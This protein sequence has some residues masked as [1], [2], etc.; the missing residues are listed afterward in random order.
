MSPLG[1]LVHSSLHDMTSI[2][3]RL[4]AARA[5]LFV[6]RDAEVEQFRSALA[7]DT[8]PFNV[9]HV[10][11]PGGVGKTELLQAFSRCCASH[12]VPVYQLD[13]RDVDPN[14]ES[15]RSALRAAIGLDDETPILAG[16]GEQGDRS[17]LLIDTVETIEA[18]DDWLR[19]QFLPDLP[20]DVVVVFAGRS[21]PDPAWRTDSGW[22][23]LVETM[24]LRNFDR[25][26]GQTLLR[27]R[28]V[29]DAQHEAILNFTHGHP[30]ATA[31]VA[32]LMEQQEDPTFE[33]A[34]A[35]DIVKT[36]LEQFVQQ[37]P[38]PAHRAALEV[39]ALVRYT[40][41]AVLRATLDISDAHELFEWV[42]T[43]SFVQPGERGVMLHDL[44][45]EALAADLQWRN[46]DWHDELH[47]RARQFYTDR[48]KRAP[49]R[50][51][52][53]VLSDFT[54]L[55][56][57]HP[58]IK[59]FY[60]RLRSQ[61]DDAHSL[62]EDTPRDDD[63]PV[64]QEMVKTQE[65][66]AAANWAQHWFDAHPDGVHVYREASGT[67][68]G[69]LLTLPLDA[70][71]AEARASDPVTEQAW[72]HLEAHAPLRPGEQA[73]LFRFWMARDTGQDPSPV[74][75]LIFIR[76]VRHYLQTAN[77]A[78][79]LL[80]CRPSE[81]WDALFRYAGMERVS[82]EPIETHDASYVLYGHDWRARPPAQWLDLL[83]E[84]GFDTTP[85]SDP[86]DQSR[87]IVLSRS[88]FEEALTDAFKNLHRPDQLDDNPLLYSRVVTAK[89][90][91]TA[92]EPE[93]IEA[94]CTLL[95]DTAER[96][97][98][99]PRDEK[100]YRAVQRTYLQPAPTQEKAA[101]QLDVPFSTF[102]RHLNR[103]LD[104][105]R[106]ILWDKEVGTA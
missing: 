43:L 95:H 80:A 64:L 58:F 23:S 31:L 81:R 13:A 24:P 25:D 104:R 4:Q 16:L 77:L 79:S 102:R 85:E 71:P 86:D 105:V 3:D 65:G 35:P 37:V 88:D 42:R 17:V 99:D 19:T 82:A 78:Y 84:R 75:S 11:G 97:S 103:G 76:Q 7:A 92:D 72:T 20:E 48:L 30:L 32:D 90:G 41:E 67:P 34:E 70:V 28:E 26:T 100:Y 9:L 101:E 63:W 49:D 29:P 6:G 94:L 14:P 44:V 59:P 56:R 54:F 46:P 69:F 45:R 40:T 98:D 66:A 18:L 68:V 1:L 38:S 27:R 52:S 21:E 74:Q 106:D 53:N 10:F 33:P 60:D 39:A 91:R 57:D 47:E 12:D 50:L 89:A 61:W 93:R 15:F 62:M 51:V 83:A 5:R 55:L 87:V 96:L 8:L 36:L 2:G 22:R 73:S